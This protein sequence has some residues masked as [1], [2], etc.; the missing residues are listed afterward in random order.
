M[1]KSYEY[2]LI[3]GKKGKK[4][5]RERGKDNG[6]VLKLV[7]TATDASFRLG[8]SQPKKSVQRYRLRD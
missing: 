8:K 7:L 6:P 2:F 4:G 3:K 5:K 1:A